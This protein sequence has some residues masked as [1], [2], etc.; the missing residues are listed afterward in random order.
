MDH[1]AI[2]VDGQLNLQ[3]AYDVHHFLPV[4]LFASNLWLPTGCPESDELIPISIFT[5]VY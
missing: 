2:E 5:D 1:S 3:G 4:L